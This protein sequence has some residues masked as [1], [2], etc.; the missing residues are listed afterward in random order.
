[1]LDPF[2]G[3][4]STAIAAATLGLSVIGIEMDGQYLRVAEK[5]TRSL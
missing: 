5:R 2:L 3:L 4:G 1:V